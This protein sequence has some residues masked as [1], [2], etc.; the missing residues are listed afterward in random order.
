MKKIRLGDSDLESS[1]LAYGCMR[2]AGDGSSDDRSR[3]KRAIHAAV[4][5]GYTL[6]DHADIYGRGACEGLF[7]E[8][9]RETPG[10]RERIVIAS[11]C[12]IRFAGDPDRDAPARYDFSADHIV[13]SVE[14]SLQRLG[15]EQIDL[16]M[17]HRPDYLMR[18]GEVAE[19]FAS[20][21]SSGKVAHFGV[22][23]FSTSQ[24]ELLQSALPAPLLVNQVEIN[25]HN[26]EALTKGVLDQCQRLG[27]T[28]QA[29][30]P[31]AGIVHP[32]WG[33][34]FSSEDEERIRAEVERQCEKYEVDS[35]DIALAWLL[36]HPACISPIIGSTNPARI[37]AATAALDLAYSREDWYRLLEE[38]NGAPVP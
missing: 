3:G 35:A 32:A 20:L 34:T 1:R 30:S 21:Q 25:L 22:S 19:A 7:G 10:L 18:P 38:R 29:W 6:F 31:I 36:R 23:N 15:I 14:V 2:I 27:V 33:N 13:Q 37:A 9:L 17:L 24:F 16:L 12:G 5:A 28:P 11:K 4:D 8:V 26:I